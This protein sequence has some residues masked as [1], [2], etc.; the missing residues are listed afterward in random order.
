MTPA[1]VLVAVILLPFLGVLSRRRLVR[2]LA[3]RNGLRRPVE[4][5]LVVIG[6]LFGTA[7]ITGSLVVADTLDWSIRQVAHSH[8][9]AIDEVVSTRDPAAFPQ[10]LDAAERLREDG[11]VDGVLALEVVPATATI[12]QGSRLQVLP[13]AQLVEM[14]MEEAA[15]FGDEGAPSGL[16]AGRLEAGQAVVNG[17]VAEGLGVDAGDEVT[18]H[19]FGLERRL[20]VTR[21]VPTVRVSQ[22][23]GVRAAR[24]TDRATC[25]WPRA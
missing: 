24:S 7:I 17:D 1:L 6:S 14:D 3:F 12:G 15:A 2:R 11:I 20:T 19:A 16:A 21:V 5:V 13:G 23:S 9:G 10:V 25:S 18:V 22:A 4:T 8:L